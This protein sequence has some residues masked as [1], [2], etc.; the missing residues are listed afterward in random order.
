[1]IPEADSPAHTRSWTL[2]PDLIELNACYNY[3]ANEWA[4]YCLEPPCGI[5][6]IL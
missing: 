3:P 6:I 2:T 5:Y 4:K 1:M